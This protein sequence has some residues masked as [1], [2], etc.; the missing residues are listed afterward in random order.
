MALILGSFI[1]FC[2]VLT[3]LNFDFSK[4]SAIV[5]F[6]AITV[7]QHTTQTG[8]GKPVERRAE[9][10]VLCNLVSRLRVTLV[11]RRVE[12]EIDYYRMYKQHES[13]FRESFGD[14]LFVIARNFKCFTTNPW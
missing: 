7:A 12:N 8:D 11:Q 13:L 9:P 10:D 6:T 1:L 3:A 14:M 4:A 2:L 5:F